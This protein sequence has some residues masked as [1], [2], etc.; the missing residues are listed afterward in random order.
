MTSSLPKLYL[1][2]PVDPGGPDW[3]LWLTEDEANDPYEKSDH[4]KDGTRYVVLLEGEALAECT[5]HQLTEVYTW[6][7]GSGDHDNYVV[8][9]VEVVL[10]SKRWQVLPWGHRGPGELFYGWN[11]SED[12][13]IRDDPQ[14]MGWTMASWDEVE[15]ALAEGECRLEYFDGRR[16]SWWT[17]EG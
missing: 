2:P 4:L 10:D 8:L 16:A 3:Q 17:S 15:Q 14:G 12:E 6:S 13:M 7:D 9:R 5:A 1:A 11:H